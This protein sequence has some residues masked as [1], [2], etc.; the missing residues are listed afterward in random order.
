MERITYFFY[1]K[2]HY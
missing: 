1:I 2:Q